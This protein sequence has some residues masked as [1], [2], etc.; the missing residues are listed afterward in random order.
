MQFFNDQAD[1]NVKIILMQTY[2]GEGETTFTRK[3]E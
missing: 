1:E 3:R 2:A